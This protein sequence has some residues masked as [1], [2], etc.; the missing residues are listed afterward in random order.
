MKGRL[1]I[2]YTSRAFAFAEKKMIEK[3][4]IGI[5]EAGCGCMAGDMFVSIVALP[6]GIEL[7]GVKDSKKLSDAQREDLVD[8][9]W[10]GAV[11]YKTI[12]CSPETIDIYGLGSMWKLLV[13]QL[14]HELRTRFPGARAIL[15]GS[16]GVGMSWVKPVVKADGKYLSVMAASV[17]SKYCQTCCM[18]AHHKLYPQYGF[19]RHRGY[20]TKAHLAAVQEHGPCPIHRTSYRPLQRILAERSQPST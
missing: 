15:D 9:I 1:Y 7:P 8:S 13:R 2:P 19:D 16:R 3:V 20:V 18:D 17:L 5:D 14:G 6:A 4:E 11:W 10:A 12:E